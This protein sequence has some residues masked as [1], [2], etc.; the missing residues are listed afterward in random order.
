MFSITFKEIMMP[1]THIGSLYI[2][3]FVP[4]NDRDDAVRRILAMFHRNPILDRLTIVVGGLRELDL[5]NTAIMSI[6]DDAVD[7]DA[8]SITSL[9]SLQERAEYFAKVVSE[10]TAV[11]MMYVPNYA[12]TLMVD[13]FVRRCKQP[14][15]IVACQPA[16]ASL[17]QGEYL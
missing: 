10:H 5:R 12:T 7:D 8:E 3:L 2:Q 14:V 6:A 17:L 16:Y 1:K 4:R 11:A 15:A 13:E 9:T